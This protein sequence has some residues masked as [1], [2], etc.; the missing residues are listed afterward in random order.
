M[1]QCGEDFECPACGFG[2]AANG[3][4]LCDGCAEQ[5]PCGQCGV[6]CCCYCSNETFKCCGKVLCGR[7]NVKSFDTYAKMQ[8]ACCIELR[9]EPCIFAHEQKTLPCGHLGCNFS[10]A[11][12]FTCEKAREQETEQALRESDAA[13]VKSLLDEGKAKSKTL[14]AALRQ[15]AEDP[16]GK[17]RKRDVDELEE[18][19][20]K[21]QVVQSR[22]TCGASDCIL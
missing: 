6:S 3:E 14:Q 11:A 7:G 20:S 19:R 9:K 8:K 16:T 5:Q 12:C 21:L 18:N 22:C 1:Q 13:L 2:G 10:G 4:S 15:W 17:K